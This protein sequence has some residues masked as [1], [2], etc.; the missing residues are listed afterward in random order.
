MKE[1]PEETPSDIVKKK[2]KPTKDL[3]QLKEKLLEWLN[4]NP[5]FSIPQHERIHV[6][7]TLSLIIEKIHE[8]GEVKKDWTDLN[9]N[10]RKDLDRLT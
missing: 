3:T 6:V 8:W 5:P 2:L 1:I 4:T 9:R 10:L 7:L